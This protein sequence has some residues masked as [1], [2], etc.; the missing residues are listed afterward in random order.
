MPGAYGGG[1]LLAGRKWGDEVDR[2]GRMLAGWGIGGRGIEG[3]E[4]RE[5]A[6]SGGWQL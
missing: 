4:N 5:E 2:E 1:L 3:G 6:G